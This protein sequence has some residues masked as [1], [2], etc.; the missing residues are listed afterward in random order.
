[1][2][3]RLNPVLQASRSAGSGHTGPGGG[4]GQ[5]E[6]SGPSE[7]AQLTGGQ[8]NIGCARYACLESVVCVL[9]VWYAA[10]HTLY[11]LTT[12]WLVGLL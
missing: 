11:S 10:M 7:M 12:W 8:T 6:Q 3:C 5:R 4:E 1:M 2:L 9:L